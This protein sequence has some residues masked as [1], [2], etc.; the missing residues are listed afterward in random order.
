[1]LSQE[2]TELHEL[3]PIH[4]VVSGSSVY[5]HQA[6]ELAG[7]VDAELDRAVLDVSGSFLGTVRGILAPADSS[8]SVG[9]YSCLQ[10]PCDSR[11]LL[12]F[13]HHAHEHWAQGKIAVM[14][15]YASVSID[16]LFDSVSPRS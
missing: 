2:K 9:L 4:S 13:H 7:E 16:C 14:T 10:S 11:T 15:R 6:E 5:A 1:M 12:P 8:N 3:P